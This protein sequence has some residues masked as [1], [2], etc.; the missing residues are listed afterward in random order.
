M[1]EEDDEGLD[2]NIDDFT[3]LQQLRILAGCTL[4]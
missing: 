1:D 2:R 4:S 3:H